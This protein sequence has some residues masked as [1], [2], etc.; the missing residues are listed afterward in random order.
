M[1]FD[2][3]KN[4]AVS[5]VATAPSPA[6]TGTSLTLATGDGSKFPQPSTDGAFNLVVWPAGLNPSTTNA[7]VVR[8]TARAG[9]VLTITRTQEGTSARTI[10][11]GDQIGLNMTA[12]LLTDIESA[13]VGTDG[14][15]SD[16]AETWTFGSFTAGPPAAGTF[17]VTGDLRTKYTVGTRIKLTQTTVKYF[18]ITADPTYNSGT[19]TTTVTISG[20]TDYTLANAAISANSHS[21]AEN[22]QGY[23]TWFAFGPGLTGFSGSP[24]TNFVFALAGRICTVSVWANGTSN[25]TTL[26]FTIPVKS[27]N[28][29]DAP[30]TAIDNGSQ[31]SSPGMIEV[32]FGSTTATAYKNWSAAGWTASGTKEIGPSQFI[33]RI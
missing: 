32:G 7:E 30:A 24:S 19:N 22:P 21:Y 3:H 14:W 25:A 8:C 12:K 4:F 5:T 9:D 1:S 15:I 13:L 18:V 29:F 6:T 23:P 17:T 11:V 27:T 20:G 31:Q 10:I 28:T 16:S 2:P 33:Y 26:T